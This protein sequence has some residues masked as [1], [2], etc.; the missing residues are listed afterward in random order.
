M[1]SRRRERVA[2]AARLCGGRRRHWT[3][4]VKNR[5]PESYLDGCPLYCT[6]SKGRMGKKINLPLEIAGRFIVHA[7]TTWPRPSTGIGTFARNNTG[8]EH[9]HCHLS[10]SFLTHLGS[11]PSH[12]WQ[13]S[14]ICSSFFP[15]ATHAIIHVAPSSKHS[16][17]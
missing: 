8:K 2:A 9:V 11:K 13:M 3:K 6:Y 1:R 15:P 14:Q 10:P 4:L 12:F 16:S 5:A 7:H 17:Y